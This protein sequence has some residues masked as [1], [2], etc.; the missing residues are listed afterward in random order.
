M[1]NILYNINII[2]QGEGEGEISKKRR[3]LS[4]SFDISHAVFCNGLK[5]SLKLLRE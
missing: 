3:N 2:E 4:L 1:I 5:H